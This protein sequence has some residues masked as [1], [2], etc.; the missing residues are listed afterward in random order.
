[1]SEYTL[2]RT[3]LP[4]HLASLMR[5]RG[6]VECECWA[7]FKPEGGLTRCETCDPE[8]W[9]PFK[10]ARDAEAS[11]HLMHIFVFSGVAAK[12]EA[13]GSLPAG[14]VER[15]RELLVEAGVDP[16]ADPS[17]SRGAR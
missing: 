9:A 6:S 17:A 7:W 15:A 8:G 16:D 10:A 4:E 5:E 3:R 2:E 11:R 1:M 14:W 12:L 13:K